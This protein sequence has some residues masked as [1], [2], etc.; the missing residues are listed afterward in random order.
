[1]SDVLKALAEVGRP[2]LAQVDIDGQTFHVR[3]MGPIE[4][5]VFLQCVAT[6]AAENS[7]VPDHTVVALGLCNPDGSRIDLPRE[8]L[9]GQLQGLDGGVLYRLATKVLELSGFSKRAV[10]AAEKN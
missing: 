4:R 6:A 8:E 5:A 9:L 3:G 2:R 1:M 10:E 7:A